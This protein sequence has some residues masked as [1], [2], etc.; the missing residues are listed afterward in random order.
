M[1]KNEKIHDLPVVIL[2]GGFGTRISENKSSLPKGLVKIGNDPIIYHI[3]KYFKAYGLKKFIICTGYKQKYIKNYFDKNKKFEDLKILIIYTGLKSNT[4]LRIKKIKKLVNENFF[5]TYCDG[6]SNINLNILFKKFNKSKKLG[7]LTAVNPQS[8]FG[9]LSIKGEENI[10]NFDEKTKLF[11]IWIN[12]GYYIFNKK[13]FDYIK[14]KNPIFEKETLKNVAKKKLIISYKHGGFWKCM[15]TIKDR[16]E[17]I[18]IWK[19]KRKKI[20]W[21]I[22]K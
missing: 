11:N 20:P 2:A 19:H 3:I 10:Y 4:G 21:K 18:S 6:L 9:I 15:D 12:A 8:R 17:L 14:G 13:I 16:K 7:I 22:W 5:L 1:L